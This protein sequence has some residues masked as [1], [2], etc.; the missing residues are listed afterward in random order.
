MLPRTT[1]WT[2]S[3]LPRTEQLHNTCIVFVNVLNV[4]RARWIIWNITLYLPFCNSVFLER[5]ACEKYVHFVQYASKANLSV[6]TVKRF[7]SNTKLV[8]LSKCLQR[9]TGLLGFSSRWFFYFWFS[10]VTQGTPSKIAVPMHA[11]ISSIWISLGIQPIG[12]SS[13][14]QDWKGLG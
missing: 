5:F 2:K 6:Y 7:L 11:T 3:C 4:H 8:W 12:L 14:V 1:V 13:L 9:L 10:R